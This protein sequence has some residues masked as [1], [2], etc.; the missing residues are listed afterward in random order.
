MNTQ[1]DRLKIAAVAAVLAMGVSM[2][3]AQA[4][5]G[6]ISVDSEMRIGPG[7]GF[8]VVGYV[9]ADAD[10]S[11]NGCTSGE[12]WCVVRYDGRHGWVRAGDVIVTGISRNRNEFDDAVIVINVTDQSSG[13]NSTA[14]VIPFVV[15]QESRRGPSGYRVIRVD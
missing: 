14:D 10:V 3:A 6:A 8:P 5:E 4:L 12:S 9:P 11:V 15:E 7:A 2:T 13:R 1:S